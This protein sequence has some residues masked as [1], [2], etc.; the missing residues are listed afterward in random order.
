MG[1]GRKLAAF[2]WAPDSVMQLAHGSV[3]KHAL[4]TR[5]NRVHL[6]AGQ[7]GTAMNLF[8]LV[9][10]ARNDVLD[11]SKATK[12]NGLDSRFMREQRR[13]YASVYGR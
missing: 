2:V 5:A 9:S 10:R 13:I 4:V 1:G 11:R 12:A 7:K 8:F 6:D 3:P